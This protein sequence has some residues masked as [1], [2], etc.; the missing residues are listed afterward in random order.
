MKGNMKKWFEEHNW[1]M[2]Q[3]PFDKINELKFRVEFISH[4]NSNGKIKEGYWEATFHHLICFEECFHFDNYTLKVQCDYK[5]HN[6]T[7]EDID[8][9][10]PF[11]GSYTLTKNNEKVIDNERTRFR[12]QGSIFSSLNEPVV[13]EIFD[14][15]RKFII[16]IQ[17][18]DLLIPFN[19]RLPSKLSNDSIGNSGEFLASY[20]DQIGEEKRSHILTKLKNIFPQLDTINAI[21]YFLDY[22]GQT[23]ILSFVEKFLDKIEFVSYHANDGILRMIAFL[24]QLESDSPFI[25]FDEIENGINTEIIDFL[26]K[27][28]IESN[29]QIVVTTH[30]PMIL[31]FIDDDIACKGVHL[32]YKTQEGFTQSI[33]FF[34][35]PRINKKLEV[36]GPGEAYVDTDLNRLIDEIRDLKNEELQLCI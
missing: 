17:V 6:T 11:L 21:P 34:S 24:S 3:T 32:F 15:I 2:I 13:D 25:L 30:S 36:L 12:Y 35:L 9:D 10:R 1:N 26:M 31:N 8:N 5:G 16:D 33:P 14:S 4:D 23:K 29:R 27:Q 28:L 22:S 18:F 20:F 19:L 7:F